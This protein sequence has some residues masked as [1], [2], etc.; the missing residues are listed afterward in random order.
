[1]SAMCSRLLAVAFLL[2]LAASSA[3]TV[4]NPKASLADIP[5]LQARLKADSGAAQSLGSHSCIRLPA[6]PAPQGH[7]II[8]HHY[9]TGSNGPV[10]PAEAP[11]TKPYNDLESRIS[12]GTNQWLATGNEAEAQCAL[13]QLDTWAQA[14]AL[15][16]YDPQESSQAWFQVEWTL[17]SL[18]IA[19][20]VLVNDAKLDPAAQARV[21]AWLDTAARHMMSFDKPN[22][23]NH[24][25]W[26][27]L[28]ATSI[29]IAA[30]D[31]SLYAAGVQAYKD[32]IAE[33]DSRGALPQEMARHENAIH[34]QSFALQPLCLIAQFA[35][36]QGDDLFAY[37]VHDRTLRD[38][39]IFLG[40]AASDPTLVRPYTADAQ[41][42]HYGPGDFAAEAFYVAHASPEGL[43]ENVADSL[44]HH[45]WQTRIGGDTLLFIKP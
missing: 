6:I 8:P 18:G 45:T 24:H 15:I 27:G 30:R 29:G 1:M 13:T 41:A 28:A 22:G 11:A 37:S 35:S 43:P 32:G 34:Y 4:R 9:L 12:S 42:G 25:Y 38:A 26:R 31:N 40:K 17:S 23:N 5:A 14:K 39:I 7:F 36:R 44:T 33:I 21:T 20:S 2:P 19:D 10:N 3:Q 16:D